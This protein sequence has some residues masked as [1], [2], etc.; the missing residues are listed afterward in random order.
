MV[1]SCRDYISDVNFTGQESDSVTL[2]CTPVFSCNSSTFSDSTSSEVQWWR[3]ADDSV[4]KSFLE[5]DDKSAFENR[6]LVTTREGIST[7]SDSSLELMF[8]AA[9]HEIVGYYA[10]TL[11]LSGQRVN[12]QTFVVY[13]E[14]P[15][16]ANGGT[17]GRQLISKKK[18]ELPS[19]GLK[20]AIS[21]FMTSIYMYV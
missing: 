16:K 17:Q 20:P 3:F 9:T 7:V 2:D 19:V 4:L 11:T 1:A 21:A 12:S 6:H 10:T 5:D 18:A 13:S 8:T 14:S 15:I